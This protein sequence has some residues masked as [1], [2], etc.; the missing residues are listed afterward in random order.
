MKFVI[1]T[2]FT[3]TPGPRYKH[4][5]DFS[6]EL[7]RELHLRD[8]FNHYRKTKEPVT[9]DLDGVFGYPTSFLEEAFGG[10]AREAS[11]NEVLEAFRFI[12]T[13]QPDVIEEIKEDILAANKK[14]R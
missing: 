13:E 7:F 1:A 11:E 14:R 4:Q 9:I 10:L 3:D 8:L 2:Q 5:G 6:G 12:A